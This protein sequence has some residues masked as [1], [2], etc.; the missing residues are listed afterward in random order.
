MDEGVGKTMTTAVHADISPLL[1]ALSAGDEARI[2]QE[3]LDLLG[4]GGVPPGHIAA[5]VAVPVAWAGG[6]GHPLLVLGAAGRIAEWMRAIPAGPEPSAAT[7]RALAPA[8]PLV[9]GLVAVA[10]RVRDGLRGPNPEL[11]TP[12]T[13]LQLESDGG[14]LP[15]LRQAYSQGDRARF[16]AIL[17]GLYRTGADY[18]SLAKNL[19]ATLDF[20]YPSGGHPLIFAAGGN[21]VLGLANWGVRVPPMIHWVVPL[22]VS[23]EADEAL[24]DQARAYAEAPGH[25]LGWLRTRLSVPKEDAAG[26]A[27]RRAVLEGDADAACGAVLTAL[28]GGATQ[29]GVASALAVA[30]AERLAAAPAGDRAA[31]DRAGHTLLYANALHQVMRESQDP[32]VFPLLY[33]GALVVNAL[34]RSPGVAPAAAIPASTPIGGLI[35]PAMLRSLEHQAASGDTTGALTTARRYIQLGHA[36]MSLA[37]VMGAAASR[38]DT[39]AVPHALPL[40]AA[41]AEEYLNL[42]GMGTGGMP[43]PS[44]GQSPLLTALVRLATE[45]AGE[46]TLSDHVRDAI[47]ARASQE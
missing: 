18:R 47:A 31:L 29:R 41:A 15:A 8:V 9:Q 12:L 40:V 19:Y 16:A 43:N 35:A 36:P 39:R 23:G 25:D 22:V 37:G 21:R 13:P 20:H 24:A 2:I 28:R 3:T 5:R 6:D 11:P 46:T 14:P 1:E 38:R 30:A 34:G 42:P 27:F 26:P 33:T 17:A 44:S 45:V 7:Q 4:P 32:E 10:D